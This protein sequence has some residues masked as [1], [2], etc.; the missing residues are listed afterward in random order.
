MHHTHVTDDLWTILQDIRQRIHEME[1][2]TTKDAAYRKE[3]LIKHS[4]IKY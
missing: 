1:R 4:V 2:D 3:V